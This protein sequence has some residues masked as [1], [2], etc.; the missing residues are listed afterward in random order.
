M[1]CAFW[2]RAR[3][4]RCPSRAR[5]TGRRAR[6]R[7]RLYAL[8]RD[9]ARFYYETLW[10]PENRAAQQY[11]ISRGLHRRTMNRFG[12]GYAPDSFHALMDAMAAK[13]YT[14]EEL[15]DAGLVSRSEKGH[16]HA[17]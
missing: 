16:E 3:A 10:K 1:R 17:I 7:E 5:P 6:R 2:P 8:C 4:W 9:A 13:G 14:R 12:L 15:L 11:F